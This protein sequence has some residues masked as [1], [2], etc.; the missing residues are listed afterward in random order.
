M[1]LLIDTGCLLKRG[2]Y[3]KCL[4]VFKKHLLESGMFLLDQLQ[5]GMH[6]VISKL[7]VSFKN[8]YFVELIAQF[9]SINFGD[10]HK[11]LCRALN[12]I[13]SVNGCDW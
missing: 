1:Y 7:N 11:L 10:E 4:M 2:V 5:Y 8:L 9:N 6:E 12:F 13:L 3:P